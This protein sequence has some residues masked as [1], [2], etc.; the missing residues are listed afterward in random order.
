MSIESDT[1]VQ[2]GAETFEGYKLVGTVSSED[3]VTQGIAFDDLLPQVRIHHLAGVSAALNQA[4]QNGRHGT[5][6]LRVIHDTKLR[7][8]LFRK[9]ENGVS[10]F[11]LS[12][13]LN[14]S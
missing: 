14:V 4:Q 11:R 5:I 6:T 1:E 8:Y 10:E 12:T 7:V 9:D 3:D 13:G 2:G